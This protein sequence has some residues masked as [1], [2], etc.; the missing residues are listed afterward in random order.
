MKSIFII[1]LFFI[2]N[3][4]FTQTIQPIETFYSKTQNG[5]LGSE[6][7][8]FYLNN[9]M[10][11]ITDKSNGSIENYGPLRLIKNEYDS[12]GFYILQYMPDFRTKDGNNVDIEK[13]RKF[14]V[15]GIKIYQFTFNKKGG[16]VLFVDEIEKPHRKTFYTS[17]GYE[18]I[19]N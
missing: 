8:E 18:L 16:Q 15:I 9:N 19:P 13:V 10:L 3:V 6:K 7:Y 12:E 5:R 1:I 4:A 2:S 17:E 14:N 11:R